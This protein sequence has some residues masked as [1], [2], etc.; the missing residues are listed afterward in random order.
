M[1]RVNTIGPSMLSGR[2]L[3]AEYREITRVFALSAKAHERGAVSA[4]E[5]YRMGAGHVTFFYDKLGFIER[6]HAAL[7]AEMQ[8]RGYS[9]TILH[10]SD[11]WR[12]KIPAIAWRD[13]VPSAQDVAVNLARLVEREPGFYGGVMVEVC[14]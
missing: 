6:R 12:D 4:P 7:V 3:V 14:S 10:A 13:W 11:G 1:T 2:H 9:P 8:S 5:K